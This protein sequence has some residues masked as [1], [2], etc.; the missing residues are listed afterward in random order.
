MKANYYY[1]QVQRFNNFMAADDREAAYITCDVVQ[2]INFAY[3]TWV[4]F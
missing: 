4:E 1:L 2:R 3:Y